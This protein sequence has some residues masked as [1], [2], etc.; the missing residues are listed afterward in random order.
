MQ[1]R[2]SLLIGLVL[3]VSFAESAPRPKDADKPLLYLPTT[4]GD[5]RV[6]EVGSKGKS[7]EAIEW[8]KRVE[9]KGDMVVVYFGREEDGPALYAYGASPDGVFRIS[10]GSFVY[11]P[12]YRLLK[13]PAKEGEK[14]ES[15]SPAMGGAP[16]YVFKFTSGTEEEVEVPA[17]KFKAIRVEA[18][19]ETNGLVTRTTYWFAVGLGA[20]KIRTQ[21][22][23]VERVQVL[24]AFTPG[25][26]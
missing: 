1:C 26:K 4:V 18:D 10:N 23:D 17:G 3:P 19:E 2:V 9:K 11:D 21:Y 20:I 13:L 16:K 7:G 14:W 8:V 12:P 25:K 6:L 22:K 5:Q 15:V 24:K